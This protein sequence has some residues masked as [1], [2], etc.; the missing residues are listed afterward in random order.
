MGRGGLEMVQIPLVGRDSALAELTGA[1]RAVL[2]GTGGCYVVEGQAG[3]GKSRLVGCVADAAAGRLSTAF[4]RAA[5]LDRAAPLRTLRTL[6]RA[7][8]MPVLEEAD[9]DDP[10]ANPARLVDKLGERITRCAHARPLLVVLDDAHWA[11]EVT[12]HILRA[13][14][15]ALADAPVLWVLARRPSPSRG[16]TQDTIDRLIDDGARRVRLGPLDHDAVAGLCAHVLGG[17]PDRRVLAMVERT[18]GNPFL[19]RELLSTLHQTGAARVADGVATVESDEVPAGF[20]SA[21]ERRLGGLSERTRW[22]LDAGAVFGRAFTVHEVAGLLGQAAVDIMPLISELVDDGVL[23]TD[24]TGLAFRQDLVRE[25][26]YTALPGPVRLALHREA[27]KV[28]HGEGRS[29]VEVAE[30]L[31]RSGRCGD[32]QALGVLGNAVRQLSPT[33]PHTAADLIL[34]MLDLMGEHDEP[35][36]RLVANAVRLLASAGRFEHAR[37]L[38]EKSLHAGLG[39]DDEATLLLGLAEAMYVAGHTAPVVDYTAR[40]LAR[41]ELAGPVR[42]QLMAIRAYALLDA[43]DVAE[44]ERTGRDAAALA[45]TIGVNAAWVCGNAARG[46]ATRIQGR[47]SEAVAHGERAVALADSIGGVVRHQHPQ[48]WLGRTLTAVDRFADADAAFT[49]GQREADQLG[50]AW[51]Q[52]LWHLHQAELMLAWGRLTEALTHAEAGLAQTERLSTPARGVPLRALL[53]RIALLRDDLDAAR[54]HVDR[55]EA[56]VADGIGTAVEEVVWTGALVRDAAG[57]PTEAVAG[58]TGVLATV[59]D[60]LHLFTHDTGVGAQLVHIARRAGA[61]DLAEVAV[62]AT[63]LLA[64][65][66]SDVPS[67]VAAALHAK[68]VLHNDIGLLRSAVRTYRSSPRPLARAAAMADTALAEDAAGRAGDAVDLME[69]ALGTWLDCGATRD[70]AKAKKALRR[71][72]VRRKFRRETPAGRAG[73]W[74]SLTQSELRVVRLVAEGLTN[75]EVAS[76]LFLSPHTVDSHLRHSFSKLGVNSRVELTRK[77]VVRD[78]EPDEVAT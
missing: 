7:N 39:V 18:G 49:M 61:Q 16:R 56:L 35:R 41:T 69:E 64:E 29:S 77:V 45:E 53:A 14:V 55:A 36:P 6:L 54:A 68:G 34:R 70:A 52:P 12:A 59:P 11:D 51:S 1:A 20:L 40:A 31:V 58:L 57:N 2:G 23:V 15:P 28:V 62:A 78:R 46:V 73:G 32:A 60:R 26:L 4:G 33:A 76:R 17:T 25:A 10:L 22:L 50:T 66:N 19:L 27:A 44:A 47:L 24:G 43:P 42:A 3:T 75:R 8:G 13:L 63:R 9:T 48:L 72:G 38:G 5:H 74:A 21:V 65:R 37:E 71:M 30:H 67:L